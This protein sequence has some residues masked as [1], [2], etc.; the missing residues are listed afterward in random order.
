MWGE[1]KLVVVMLTSTFVDYVC[2]LVIANGNWRQMWHSPPMLKAGQP[3]TR[4]QRVALI[5]SLVVNL[6]FLAFFKYANWGI[7]N[8]TSLAHVLGW[9]AASAHQTFA[10]TLPLGISFYTFQSMSYSID[11]YRGHAQATRSLL[12]YA[13][14]ITKFP[15]LIA[16]PI[17]R[18]ADVAQQLVSRV[19][20]LEKFAYGVRRFA[21]GLGKKVLI[22]NSMAVPADAIF[23]LPADQLSMPVAWFGVIAYGLQIYFDFSGYSDMAIGLG[24]MLGFTFLEN[25]NYPYIST[26]IKDFW[27]RWHISL[28][29][30]FRDYLYIPLGGNRGS[31]ART[32]FNLVFVFFVTG[33][34]HGASWTFVMW[35]LFH[36]LFLIVERLWPKRWQRSSLRPL[37][38]IYTLVVVLL[39]WV[40]FR[41]ESLSSAGHI[42]QALFGVSGSAAVPLAF[43]LN[44]KTAIV[45]I[46]G[47]IGS[48]PLFLWLGKKRLIIDPTTSTAR[49]QPFWYGAT[50]IAIG[51]IFLLAVMQL[52]SGTYNPFIYYRF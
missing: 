33:L 34:W 2:A 47:L 51:L 1:A 23:A 46:L 41:A 50:S 4:T 39:G 31:T 42:Y 37:A 17:I 28:S 29:S 35:G 21:V 9:T 12:N 48:A 14:L 24:A 43:Y 26:S 45:F 18:Y 13:T 25:F 36:G 22:A 10:V 7:E 5:L 52:A 11:I 16:G 6:G 49:L 38:H 19:M 40:L 32:Y 44:G 15:L 20:S 3:R 27:R 8:V 30:W